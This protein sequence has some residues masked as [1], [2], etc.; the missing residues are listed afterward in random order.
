MTR[1]IKKD[2]RHSAVRANARTFGGMIATEMQRLRERAAE[3]EE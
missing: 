3:L 1:S 2:K